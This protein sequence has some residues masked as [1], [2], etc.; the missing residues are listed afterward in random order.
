M[1]L[2]SEQRDDHQ[3][4]GRP[5]VERIGDAN[6]RPF[7]PDVDDPAV[8]PKLP[9]PARVRARQDRDVVPAGAS[10]NAN[11]LP[12]L[13]TSTTATFPPKERRTARS[14]FVGLNGPPTDMS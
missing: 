10:W 6:D 3:V 1:G 4:V 9:Q 2:V 8:V 11:V 7:A 5:F 13:P 12:M 14:I